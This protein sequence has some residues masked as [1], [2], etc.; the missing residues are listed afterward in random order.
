[1]DN[2]KCIK[3]GEEKQLIEFHSMKRNKDGRDCACKI[4]RNKSRREKAKNLSPEER[5][6][7]LQEKRDFHWKN[8]E[9]ILET[10]RKYNIENA[11]RHRKASMEYYYNNKP[12]TRKRRNKYEKERKEKDISFR[13]SINLRARVREAIKSN[14]TEKAYSTIDLIGCHVSELKNF[15]ELKFKDG[16]SWNNYGEWE[17]DHIIPC[18]SFDLTCNNQQKKCFNYTNLQPL[19]KKENRSKGAKILSE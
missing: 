19:W 7:K 16:M 18:S 4:C 14:G 15:L 17:I 12:K 6:K 10:K 1:M 3:C 13:L 9:K 5:E 8:R 2:K 11:E